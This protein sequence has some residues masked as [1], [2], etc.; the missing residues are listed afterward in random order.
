MRK[1][2]QDLIDAL[3][4]IEDK[5]LP[6]QLEGCDCYGDFSGTVSLDGDSVLVCR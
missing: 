2:V 3:N 6:V 5:T 1:T 4:A